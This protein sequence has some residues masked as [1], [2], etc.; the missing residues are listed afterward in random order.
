MEPRGMTETGNPQ[1]WSGAFWDFF[2]ADAH[3][4]GAPL[5]VRLSE[6]TRHDPELCALASL[7]RP[8]QPPANLLFGAVHFLL[9][10]GAPHELRAHYRTLGGGGAAGDPFPL[11]KDFCRLHQDELKELIRNRVTNTN[12][13]ARCAYLHAGFLVIAADVPSPLHLIEIGASAGLNLFWD[14]YAYRYLQNGA[15]YE[16]GASNA[17]LVLET[18]LTGN[19][20][21]LGPPPLVGK[22]LGLELYPVDLGKPED[23]DW[24]RALVWPDHP[25]RMA[26]LT[27]ALA[28]NARHPPD[29]RGGDALELLLDTAAEMPRDGALTIFHTMTTYQFSDAQTATLR[30]LML[31]ISL[32]RPVWRLAMEFEGG[33]FALYLTGYRDGA[34]T[35]RFLAY[36]TGHGA[37]LDWR[38]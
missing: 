3:R 5:Y 14:A 19:I 21:P 2:I 22:R 6:G 23:R 30:D 10:R 12:E 13:V 17:E 36:G 4:L 8:G 27:R 25:E 37:D 1:A 33:K 9:L 16:A 31:L 20:P 28:V 32:R 15:V 26:R 18:R 29:I 24:L 11:F 7:A 34:E 35:T 38:A